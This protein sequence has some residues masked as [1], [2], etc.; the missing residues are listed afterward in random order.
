MKFNIF[1]RFKRPEPI[2]SVIYSILLYFLILFLFIGGTAIAGDIMRAHPLLSF[3]LLL[4]CALASFLN[5][6]LDGK[7]SAWMLKYLFYATVI[8]SGCTL[9]FHNK[10]SVYVQ[11]LLL[12]G[13]VGSR[14]VT[15]TD[16]ADDDNDHEY[17]GKEYYLVGGNDTAKKAISWGFIILTIGTPFLTWRI[18]KLAGITFPSEYPTV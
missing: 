14:E 12:G 9:L 17:E 15:E 11:K 5:Y 8:L 1:K 3:T 18:S 4:C 16:Y 10:S 13:K 7:E 2:G 6:K